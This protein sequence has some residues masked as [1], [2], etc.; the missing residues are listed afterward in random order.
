LVVFGR[1]APGAGGVVCMLLEKGFENRRVIVTLSMANGRTRM[2]E[3]GMQRQLSESVEKR[4]CR[5]AHCRPRCGG[6]VQSRG[7]RGRVE[8]RR[9]QSRGRL[10]GG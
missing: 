7:Q 8:L 1:D 10:S 3:C 5:D 9:M 4:G 2:C 6:V